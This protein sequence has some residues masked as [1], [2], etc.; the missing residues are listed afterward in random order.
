[1]TSSYSEFRLST[2]ALFHQL[3]FRLKL[4]ENGKHDINRR[5]VVLLSLVWFPVLALAAAEGNLANTSLDV[6]LLYEIAI[7][8]RVTTR[9]SDPIVPRKLFLEL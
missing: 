4:Q 5:G 2:G 8:T 1:M 9:R 6:P 7:C 3:S